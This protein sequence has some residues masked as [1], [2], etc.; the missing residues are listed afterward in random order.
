MSTIV[1]VYEKQT[2][3]VVVAIPVDED[4]N[5]L[6]VEMMWHFEYLMAQSRYSLKHRLAQYF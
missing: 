1:V 4:I 5:Q 6:Y 3:R 2:K